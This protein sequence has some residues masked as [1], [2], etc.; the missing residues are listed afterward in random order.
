MLTGS[1]VKIFNLAE[2]TEGYETEDF[3]N[4]DKTGLF[5]KHLPDKI[6]SFKSDKLYLKVLLGTNCTGTYKLEPVIIG[7]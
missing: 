4:A 5:Y 1:D 6:L 3:F 2:Q 7:K